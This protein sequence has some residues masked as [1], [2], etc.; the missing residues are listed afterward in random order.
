[1]SGEPRHVRDGGCA[2]AET[3]SR[4]ASSTNQPYSNRYVAG[5]EKRRRKR[6][7]K[8]SKL[9]VARIRRSLLLGCTIHSAQTNA[10]SHIPDLHC[11]TCIC[12]RAIRKQRTTKTAVQQYRSTEG[13]HASAKKGHRP[14]RD[15]GQI[16]KVPEDRRLISISSQVTPRHGDLTGQSEYCLWGYARA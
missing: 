13:I 1:M 7:S 2:I 12:L 3:Y 14:L 16:F 9:V 10:S 4:T 6:R 15:Y 8:R 5:H 11:L